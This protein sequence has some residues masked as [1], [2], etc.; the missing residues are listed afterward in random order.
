MTYA[1]CSG[2]APFSG[3]SVLSRAISAASVSSRTTAASCGGRARSCCSWPTIT[4][5]PESSSRNPSR[6]G[7]YAGSS[8][9]VGTS[10][11]Q[12]PE[13]ADDQVERAFDAEADE[14]VGTDAE[15]LQPVRQLVRARVQ[16]PVAKRRPLEDDGRRRR[17]CAPPAPR[18]GDAAVVTR[19]TGPSRPPSRRGSPSR[20]AGV[21][22]ASSRTRRRRIRGDRLEQ[23]EQVPDHALG[24]LRVEQIRA[25][26]E[27]PAEPRLALLEVEHEVEA[28]RC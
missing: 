7:G 2:P 13:D 12:D 21:S 19:R 4:A 5:T 10:G 22:R 16:L 24:G 28:R 11:L 15:A 26:L 20:S 9:Q 25:E 6:S 23:R 18:S 27:G 14:D 8:G 3:L 17:A 1:R